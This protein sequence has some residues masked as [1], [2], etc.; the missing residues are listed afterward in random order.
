MVKRQM[1]KDDTSTKIQSFINAAKELECNMT[2]EE[3][4]KALRGIASIKP[5]TND[6]IAKKKAA[7]PKKGGLVSKG[8][9]D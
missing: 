2:E 9:K 5:M 7:S 3:F 6:E 4:A 1:N 8:N